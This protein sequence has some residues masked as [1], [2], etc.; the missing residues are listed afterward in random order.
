ML[1]MINTNEKSH[2]GFGSITQVTAL[3][4]VYKRHNDIRVR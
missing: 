1:E 2:A 4:P 3:C